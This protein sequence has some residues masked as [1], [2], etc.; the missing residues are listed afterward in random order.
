MDWSS[1]LP[2]FRVMRAGKLI[3]AISFTPVALLL[4]T[5]STIIYRGQALSLSIDWWA[6]AR[7]RLLPSIFENLNEMAL[8]YFHN[9]FLLQRISLRNHNLLSTYF[10]FSAV[11]IIFLSKLIE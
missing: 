9:P 8:T 4:S 7:G 1:L 3:W 5:I 11:F 6:V 10:Y 2:K